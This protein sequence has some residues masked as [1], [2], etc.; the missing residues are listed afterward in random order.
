MGSLIV[1]S[2]RDIPARSSSSGAARPQGASFRSAFKKRWTARDACRQ[3][4]FG[5]L[6][7]RRARS[8]PRPCG[9]DPSRGVRGAARLEA[10]FTDEELERLNSREGVD[11]NRDAPILE[12][13]RFRVR[14]MYAVRL[15]SVRH[16]RGA[17]FFLSRLRSTVGAS[18]RLFRA[19]A[20]SV[21]SGR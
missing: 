12:P 7:C 20:M 3:R 5:R 10:K 19:L 1:I 9:D 13:R 6:P 15:W 4:Q 2:W 11:A 18:A 8:T 21:S 17:E 14:L 16:A